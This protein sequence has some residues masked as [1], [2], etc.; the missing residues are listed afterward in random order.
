MVTLRAGVGYETSPIKDSTRDILL[1]TITAC[2][3]EPARPTSI[4]SAQ[5]DIGY[6]TCSSM[7]SVLRGQR[8]LNG[9]TTHCN[10]GTPTAV[11]PLR[12]STDSPSTSSVSA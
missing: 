12:G 9:G 6:P 4:P 3:G 10:A 1:Q 11:V 7:I 5:P 2:S 8:F